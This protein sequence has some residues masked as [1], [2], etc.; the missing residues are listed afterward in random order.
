[1]LVYLNNISFIIPWSEILKWYCYIDDV[2]CL[3][4]GRIDELHEFT[5]LH[6]EKDPNLKFTMVYD[7]NRVYFLDMWIE[8]RSGTFC[9]SLYRQDTD[10]NTCS[11]QTRSAKKSFL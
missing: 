2:Y 7:M 3:F 8:E 1:M 4:M 11:Y 10:R 6:N 9:T 5:R